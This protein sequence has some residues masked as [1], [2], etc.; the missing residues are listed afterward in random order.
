MKLDKIRYENNRIYATPNNC[1]WGEGN[2]EED[3]ETILYF[4]LE[5][6]LSVELINKTSKYLYCLYF[7]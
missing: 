5:T 7:Y 3:H 6:K 4:Q 1:D 2:E